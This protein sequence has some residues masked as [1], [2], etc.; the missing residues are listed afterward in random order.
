MA[1][2]QTSDVTYAFPDGLLRSKTSAGGG[3][4][5]VTARISWPTSSD[6]YGTDHRIPIDRANLG[7][8]TSI[9]SFQI[10]EDGG[11]G[12]VYR[13]ENVN[14]N[15]HVFV[16]SIKTGAGATSRDVSWSSTTQN[17][18]PMLNEEGTASGAVFVTSSDK[19]SNAENLTFRM[20]A[21]VEL[22]T[23]D[24]LTSSTLD[25]VVIGF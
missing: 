7:F 23:G 12:Y 9:E 5:R 19:D 17:V 14:E 25:V 2:F 15:L 11:T 21:L 3:R 16:P 18:F 24:T 10:M 8:R 6:A 22:A 4:Y 13:Y 20:P 1:N